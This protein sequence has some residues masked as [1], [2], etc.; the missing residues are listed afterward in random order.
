LKMLARMVKKSGMDVS[1]Q[2]LQQ[3]LHQGIKD[4]DSIWAYYC[5]LTMEDSDNLSLKLP[6]G[7]PEVKEYHTDISPYDNLLWGGRD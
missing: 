1:T 7:V 3:I 2:I 6:P 5:R 4:P